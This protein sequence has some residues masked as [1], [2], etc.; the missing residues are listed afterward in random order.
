MIEQGPATQP[1]MPDLSLR[2][3]FLIATVLSLLFLAST[4]YTS[5]VTLMDRIQATDVMK[6]VSGDIWS[7]KIGGQMV[8]FGFAQII[9][10]IGMGALAWLIACAS[11]ALWPSIRRKFGRITVGWFALLSAATLPLQ[12]HARCIQGESETFSFAREWC[13][14]PRQ[15]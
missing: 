8:Y 14:V 4:A 1:D 11:V 10:H 9:L 6:A 13:F 12:R 3:G 5:V 7:P 2:R 15:V